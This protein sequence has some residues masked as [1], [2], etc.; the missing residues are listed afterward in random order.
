M[1]KEFP[2]S[3]LEKASLIVD[4]IYRGGSA[5]NVGDDPLS[6][7]MPCGNQGGF[8][9]AKRPGGGY[10]MAVL[11]SS[12]A[13]PDWPDSLDSQTGLYTYFGDNK[14]PGGSLAGPR[15][16]RLLES[17]FAAAHSH[18]RDP[19][20]LP[21][22][23]VF[24]SAVGGRSVRYLGLAAPGGPGLGTDDL[25]A[26]WRSSGG[27]RF[28]NYRARFT[29][30]DAGEIPRQWVERRAYHPLVAEPTIEYR[31]KTQQ[32]PQTEGGRALVR[33][34]YERFRNRP[35]DFEKCADRIWKLIAPGVTESE[36]TR[37]SRDGGYDASGRYSLGPA[38]DPIRITFA[39]EA[40]CYAPDHGAGV[41]DVARLISR[42]LH[43]QF[44]VFVT[45]SF[46]NQEA[47][48][49]VRSDKHPV[50]V[51]S[52]ADIEAALR[53]SGITTIAATNAWLDDLD[54]A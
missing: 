38:S 39:L 10:R 27:S 26:V 19:M 18:A 44:G 22:F 9:I 14:T 28:Q 11:Y 41:R 30:L 17:A 16:N 21:P 36:I 3:D 50:V 33:T 29:V 46:V 25:V 53:A 13:D 48:R 51:V 37:P 32:L 35:T 15:G 34:I 42:L 7:L 12:G 47:Y 4:A 40:K 2:F 8:R 1:S 23:F 5:G 6:R 49:E 54:R 31:T 52:G 45:T 24:Q 20:A 43:R